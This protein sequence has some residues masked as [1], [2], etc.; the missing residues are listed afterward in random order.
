MTDSLTRRK[1]LYDE[2]QERT[3]RITRLAGIVCVLCLCVLFPFPNHQFAQGGE[4]PT[5]SRWANMS[6]D[7]RADTSK[8]VTALEIKTDNEK[9]IELVKTKLLLMD[10]K[11]ARLLSRLSERITADNKSS[12]SGI[13]F[14]LTAVLI[15]LS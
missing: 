9:P 4:N 8:I 14:L 12:G 13:A 10:D 2:S 6:S 7:T 15:I 3:S 5:S 1:G 11:Q